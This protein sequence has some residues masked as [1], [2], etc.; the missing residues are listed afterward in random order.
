MNTLL[1]N[2]LKFYFQSPSNWSSYCNSKCIWWR[3][4]ISNIFQSPS[5]WSSY[6]NVTIHDLDVQIWEIAFSLLVIGVVIVIIIP[7][8][9]TPSAIV[10]QSPSNWSSYCN[11]TIN[12]CHGSNLIFQSPSNW[13]SYCNNDYALAPGDFVFFQSPSN[14][15]SYCN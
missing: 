2:P 15:S 5:N 14:W 11:P 8:L 3:K 12:F 1:P 13:S 6:C 7:S 9:G 10:F 4:S